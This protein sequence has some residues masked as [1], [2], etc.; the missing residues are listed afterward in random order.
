[1]LVNC[2]RPVVSLSES[3]STSA[4]PVKR[5][6]MNGGYETISICLAESKTV[7]LTAVHGFPGPNTANISLSAPVLCYMFI[8]HESTTHLMPTPSGR[9]GSPCFVVFA[10]ASTKLAV[11]LATMLAGSSGRPVLVVN[12]RWVLFPAEKATPGT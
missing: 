6:R 7:M 5:V 8:T 11:K 12:E 9:I 3:L 4:P 1:M 2:G 10:K